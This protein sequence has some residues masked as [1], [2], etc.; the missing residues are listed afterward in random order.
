MSFVSLDSLTTKP[1]TTSH[2]RAKSQPNAKKPQRKD[3]RG[4]EYCPLNEVKGINKIFGKVRGKK[5]FLWAQSPGMQENK[6]KT[7]LIG[8]SGKWLWKELKRVGINREDC[9]IQNVVRCVPAD[10]VKN[11]WPPLKMRT[12]TKEEVKC[13]S[14]YNDEAVSKSKAKIHLVFGAIAAAILLKKEYKKDKRVFYSDALKA[15]VVYLDHP[16]YFIRQGYSAE[17]DKPANASLVRF[18]QDLIKAKQIFQHNPVRF[19]FLKKQNY[20]GITT[21]ALARKVY[22]KLKHE[23]LNGHRLV[24]DTE[25]GKINGKSVPLCCGFAYKPGTS[26]VFPL[27]HPDAPVSNRC[28]DLNYQLVRK[29]IKNPKIKKSAHYLPSDVGALKD[30]FGV[31]AKGFNYDT[32]LGEYFRDPDIKSY[33][34]DAIASRRYPNFQDYKSIE[35]PDAFTPEFREL[36]KQKKYSK[37]SLIQQVMLG[38]TKNGINLA[39]LPWKK[40]L[41]YNGADCHL[42]TLVERD[43]VSFVNPTLMEV[44]IDA[45]YVLYRMQ[46]DKECMPIFDYKWHKKLVNLWPIKVKKYA[47]RLKKLAGKYAY[48]PHKKTGEIVKKRFNPGSGDHIKWLLY[49]KLKYKFPGEVKPNVKVKP[50]TKEGTLLKLALTHHKVL[51][52]IEYRKAKKADSTYVHGFYKCANL[53]DGYLRTNWKMTGTGTGRF[54]SGKTKDKAND[55][56]VNFQNIHGDPL[57]KCLLVS[58]RRWYLMYKFWLKHGDFDKKTWRKFRNLYV[59]IGFDFSQNELRQLAEESG[60]KELIRMFSSKEKWFCNPKNKGCGKWHLPDPHVEVGHELT[61]WAKEVIAHNDQFR[62]LVKNMQFGLV[63][64]LQGPGLYR[65]IIARGVKTTLDEVNKYHARYFKRFRGVEKLQKKYRAFVKKHGYVKNVF[66]FRRNIN[67]QEYSSEQKHDF[68]EGE[69]RK[70][71]YWANVAINTPIQGSSHQYLVMSIAALH[72]KPKEYK[73]VSNPNKEIHD[74][75]YF[76]QRLKYLFKT[77]KQG[78]KL[79]VDEPTRIVKEEFKLEKRVPLSAKP[80]AGFRFGVQLEGIG[81]EGIMNEWDFLNAWCAENKKLEKSYKHELQK[82]E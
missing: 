3:K 25:S 57:I 1:T 64:G 37:L 58:D 36:L 24:V 34:L 51:W 69:D 38:R 15:W 22:R 23:A 13:C 5:I 42:E 41:L 71:S 7:E 62:K 30:L 52:I 32:L 59:D 55:A 2:G 18:R 19:S 29:L 33:G 28:R 73:L 46:H 9:D 26:Y 50:N 6:Q 21:R 54:S 56:V 11:T 81:E 74:A 63:F 48:I 79:M 75:L 4:C 35:G 60:D 76:R 43:T 68:T 8:P 66:G 47:R 17:T 77:V 80:K 12:P 44:Y 70:G 16:S 31:A 40:M 82:L 65:F 27:E 61:N 14:I 72:R 10:Q 78:M 67:V 20:I 53:N 45:S 39:L 49:T